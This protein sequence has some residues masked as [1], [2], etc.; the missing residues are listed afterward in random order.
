M[1]LAGRL[2]GA[3]SV[4]LGAGTWMGPRACHMRGMKG[5]QTR[6]VAGQMSEWVNGSGWLGRRAGDRW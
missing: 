3:R 1:G 6:W 2:R 4:P 5:S